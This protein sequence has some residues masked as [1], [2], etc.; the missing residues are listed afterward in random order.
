MSDQ[1][2]TEERI[3]RYNDLEKMRRAMSRKMGHRTIIA[4]YYRWPNLHFRYLNPKYR[5]EAQKY[6]F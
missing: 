2:W 5:Q 6:G 1:H 4:I 3:Y